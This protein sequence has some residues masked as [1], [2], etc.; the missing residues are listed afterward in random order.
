MHSAFL[1]SEY[2]LLPVRTASDS[3]LKARRGAL[4]P[5]PQDFRDW[6]GDIH[7]RE[8]CVEDLWL[9]VRW[10]CRSLLGVGDITEPSL[11]ERWWSVYCLP[12]K[13]PLRSIDALHV[14]F[15][16]H[17]LFKQVE[18]SSLFPR[19]HHHVVTIVI[20]RSYTFVSRPRDLL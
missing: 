5:H 11:T 16:E 4:S 12:Y 3:G 2:S 18:P 1:E 10:I 13:L 20:I 6:D 14:Q 7:T 8:A 17:L 19:F 15:S 9:E